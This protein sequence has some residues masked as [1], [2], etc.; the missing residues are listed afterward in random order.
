[1]RPDGT[2]VTRLTFTPDISE[3]DP[4][5]SPD[6]SRIAYS[7]YDSEGN[8]HLWMMSRD[9]FNPRQLTSG[10]VKDTHPSWSGAMSF[11]DQELAFTRWNGVQWDLY[12]LALQR[13]ELYQQTNDAAVDLDPDWAW[14]PAVNKLVFQ[15]NRANPN[16][17]L[18]TLLPHSGNPVR[19]VA[20]PNGDMQPSWSPAGDRIT[21]WGTRPSG[22][23]IYVMRANGSDIH[24]I[25]PQDLR[26]ASPAW[27]PHGETILFSGYRPDDGHSEIMRVQADGSGLALLTLNTATFD[28]DPGWLP[29]K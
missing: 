15:S 21:F 19:L 26:P 24:L 8:I 12:T 3:Q 28:Y 9:G 29:G 13:V 14:H 23:A 25:V 5:G 16:S 20:N 18:F 10:D 7:R 6:G 22:Q 17:E 11:H 27:A 2:G 1:M 4:N